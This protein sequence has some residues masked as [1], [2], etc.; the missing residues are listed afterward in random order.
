VFNAPIRWDLV[1]FYHKNAR[2]SKMQPVA[3]KKDAGHGYSAESWGPG[4]AVARVPR[5]KG[6]GTHASG[7]GAF[8]NMCRGGHMY[9]PK[10]IWKRWTRKTNLNKRRYAI[11]STVSASALT[12]LVQGRGHRVN[13]LNEL[14]FVVDFDVSVEKTKKAYELFTKLG[15]HEDIEASKVSKR[16][17]AGKGKY[18]N[19][20]YKQKK[21]PLVIHNGE[22]A[23]YKALRNLPGLEFCNVNSLSIL[24]LAPGGHLG[25]LCVWTKEAFEQLDKIFGTATHASE[26][27]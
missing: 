1:E 12:A 19:R 23:K 14:P 3:V 5:I 7:S 8:A 4:R 20:R 26:R 13:K 24:K 22:T 9:N 15:L 2:L 18:R 17:R 10:R 25:R 27:K 21:G 11:A 16:V 6:G